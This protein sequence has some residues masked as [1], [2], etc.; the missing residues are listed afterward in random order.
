MN[1]LVTLAFSAL[2]RAVPKM[3]V[4]IVSFS[5]RA[6]VGLSLLG[7]AGALV[8]RYLYVEFGE[9][10]IRMLQLMPLKTP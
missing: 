3:N 7:S 8:A 9:L 5:A 6:L 2:G 10:P 4:F 1:F